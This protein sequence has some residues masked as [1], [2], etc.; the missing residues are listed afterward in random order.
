MRTLDR[1]MTVTEYVFRL[2]IYF[3]SLSV[4]VVEGL[5]DWYLGTPL[6]ILWSY[7]FCNYVYAFSYNIF[8]QI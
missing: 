4:V 5:Q 2:N 8:A 3:H 1:W 6:F 7:R